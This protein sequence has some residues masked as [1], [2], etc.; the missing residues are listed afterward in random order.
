IAASSGLSSTSRPRARP[1]ASTSAPIQAR[2]STPERARETLEY[3]CK[4]ARVEIRLDDQPISRPLAIDGHCPIHHHEDE[5]ELLLAYV[6]RREAL[7]GYYHGGLTLH[8]EHDDRLPY[9]AFKIDSRYLEHTLTRD[10]VIRDDNFDKAMAIVAKLARTRLLEQLLDACE[11]AAIER[12]FDEQAEFLRARLLDAIHAG[13]PQVEI[14]ERPLI[15]TVGGEPVSLVQV[16]R[17]IKRCWQA[18]AASPVTERLR[19][20]GDLVVELPPGS[21]LDLCI[22]AHAGRAPLEITKVCTPAPATPAEREPWERL[23]TALLTVLRGLELEV[24]DIA[25]GHLGY[26][27]SAVADRVAITQASFG[28]LTPI[29]QIGELSSGWFRSGRVVVLNADHPTVGQLLALAD[30]EAELAAY[31]ALKLFFLRTKLDPRLDGRLA[32]LAAEARW[33]RAMI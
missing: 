3:W 26:P 29:E 16:R 20:N 22:T 25:L 5:T 14:F 11:Q 4:H 27:G 10:N 30:S 2:S 31:L 28:E 15:P 6:E 32:S 18:P 8:E 23:R 33:Q 21:V 24:G 12:R 19:A 13:K 7:R 17:Q 1:S 9:V